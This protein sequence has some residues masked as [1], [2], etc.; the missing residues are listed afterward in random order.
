MNAQSLRE[1]ALA[2]LAAQEKEQRRLAEETLQRAME[3]DLALLENLLRNLLGLEVHP[4]T[5][6][7]RPCAYVEGMCF[8]LDSDGSGLDAMLTCLM[9]AHPLPSHTRRS[10]ISSLI[11]IARLYQEHEAQHAFCREVL[12]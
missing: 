12:K 4:L 6:D 10:G 8:M 9:A 1:R 7:G 3:S 2:A 11:E 5:E